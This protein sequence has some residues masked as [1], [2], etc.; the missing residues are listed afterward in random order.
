MQEEALHILT[1]LNAFSVHVRASHWSSE[2]YRLYTNV[3]FTHHFS[4]CSS[5]PVRA[6]HWSSEGYRL[7][8]YVTFTYHLSPCSSMVRASH[9]SSEGYR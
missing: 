1:K 7:Y 2:G 9:W 3:T 5:M 8:T 6:S 4:R